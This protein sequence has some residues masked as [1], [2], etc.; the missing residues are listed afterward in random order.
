MSEHTTANSESEPAWAGKLPNPEDVRV[1]LDYSDAL[2]QAMGQNRIQDA[3]RAAA[4]ALEALSYI[5]EALDPEG[6]MPAAITH[7]DGTYIVPEFLHQAHLE[8]LDSTP[9]R[10]KKDH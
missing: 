10:R 8:F 1:F 4:T 3:A 6:T 7:Q 5:C 9:R 2:T